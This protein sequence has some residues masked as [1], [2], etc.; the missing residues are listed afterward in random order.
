M[1]SGS[2]SGLAAIP[3]EFSDRLRYYEEMEMWYSGDALKKEAVD[4]SGTKYDLYPLHFN[5]FPNCTDRS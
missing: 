5:P 1:D 2:R 3:S 4:K